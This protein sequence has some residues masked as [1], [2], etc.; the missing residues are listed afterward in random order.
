MACPLQNTGIMMNQLVR[1]LRQGIRMLRRNPG[2]TAV[3]LLSLALG[4]GANTA[5]FSLVNAVLL[6]PLPFPQPER[7][8]LVWEDAS[9][10]GFPHNT[11]APANYWDWKNQ[12]HTFKDLAAIGDRNFNLTGIGEPERVSA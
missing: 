2:F 4:I 12:N 11:P 1:D 3:A 8:A 7:L 10:V 9:F 5:I 6:R